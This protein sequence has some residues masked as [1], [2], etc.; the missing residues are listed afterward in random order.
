M[1]RSKA[2]FLWTRSYLLTSGTAG[3]INSSAS[4]TAIDTLSDA[5]RLLCRRVSIAVKSRVSIAVQLALI[6]VQNLL[7]ITGSARALMYIKGAEPTQPEGQKESF[8]KKPKK[9][10]IVRENRIF[11]FCC[12]LQMVKMKLRPFRALERPSEPPLLPPHVP[13]RKLA[14]LTAAPRRRAV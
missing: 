8:R 1:G 5:D 12:T 10:P 14:A 7:F 2:S 11:R 9:N 4:C 13:P 3:G 6:Q